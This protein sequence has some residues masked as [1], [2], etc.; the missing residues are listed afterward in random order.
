MLQE[1]V[2]DDYCKKIHRF[3]PSG[4]LGMPGLQGIKGEPGYPGLRG[5][6]GDPPVVALG[7]KKLLIC[8]IGLNYNHRRTLRKYLH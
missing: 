7:E 2:R 4:Q 1:K 3:C 8:Y 5:Q 6:K